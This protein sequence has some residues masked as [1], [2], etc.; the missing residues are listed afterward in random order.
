MEGLYL[1]ENEKPSENMK[2]YYSCLMNKWRPEAFAKFKAAQL[3]FEAL[4]Q[5]RLPFK[6][7]EIHEYD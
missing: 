1:L 3:E 7:G 6:E 2:Q 4:E 5:S